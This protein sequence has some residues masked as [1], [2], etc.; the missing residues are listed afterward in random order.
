MFVHV[1]IKSVSK[2]ENSRLRFSLK[3]AGRQ[4]RKKVGME[5]VDYYM[6]I[7]EAYCR[8]SDLSPYK[9]TSETLFVKSQSARNKRRGETF[10]P[11]SILAGDQ[12]AC[13]LYLLY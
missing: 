9:E 12:S 2:S 5:A 13:R 4:Y 1:L 6:A 8:V 10:L 7:G 11:F 3:S